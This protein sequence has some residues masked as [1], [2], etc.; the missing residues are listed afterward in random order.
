MKDCFKIHVAHGMLLDHDPKVFDR[1]TYVGTVNTKPT[2]SCPVTITWGSVS[3]NE[4][5]ER[6]S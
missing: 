6:S 3:T 1:Y 5:T 4:Q 2:W